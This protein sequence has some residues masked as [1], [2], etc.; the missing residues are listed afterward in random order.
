MH[1]IIAQSVTKFSHRHKGWD[2]E[3]KFKEFNET[4]WYSRQKVEEYQWEILSGL[5]QHAYKNTVYYHNLL[6]EIGFTP[7]KIVSERS[8]EML[9]LLER[10]IINS[11]K[12]ELISGNLSKKR[13]VPN[14]TG[15]ST[16]EPLKF[17]G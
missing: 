12:S 16:G 5:I 1:N 6:T 2:S 14:S 15:G 9:P 17:H 4:Q 3:S 13:F 7:E 11:Q 10:K 8:L